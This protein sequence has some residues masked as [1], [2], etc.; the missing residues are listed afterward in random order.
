MPTPKTSKK[1]LKVAEI[2]QKTAAQ[3]PPA[4]SPAEAK[5]QEAFFAK[6]KKHFDAQHVDEFQKKWLAL[7]E[8]RKKY[9]KIT[10]VPLVAAQEIIAMTNDLIDHVQGQK[11]EQSGFLKRIKTGFSN[12][13]KNPA[14]YVQDK[15][16]DV[17][18]KAIEIKEAGVQKVQATASGI[19]NSA[20]EK[21]GEAKAKTQKMVKKTVK[22]VEVKAQ[23]ATRK[24]TNSVKKVTKTVR[25]K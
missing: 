19:R 22:K 10:D 11:A 21:M 17:K 15:A 2:S 6:F 4:V 5:K 25:K 16:E 18:D 23:T 1:T 12:F 9:E 7:P 20:Q 24:A 14:K 8:N 13:F 3:T